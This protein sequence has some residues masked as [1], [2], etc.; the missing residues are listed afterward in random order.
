MQCSGAL[1]ITDPFQTLAAMRCMLLVWRIKIAAAIYTQANLLFLIS[2]LDVHLLTWR[3]IYHCRNGPLSK[4]TLNSRFS[5][6]TLSMPM[7]I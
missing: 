4:L 3:P 7:K 6:Q 1:G 2:F 5:V